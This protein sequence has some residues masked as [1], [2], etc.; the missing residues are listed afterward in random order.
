[1]LKFDCKKRS[2]PICCKDVVDKVIQIELVQE[3]E[4]GKE[5]ESDGE[6][7]GTIIEG[8]SNNSQ[9]NDSAKREEAKQNDNFV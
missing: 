3:N 7:T 2:N 9:D 4:K 8:E 6:S 5:S 1:M